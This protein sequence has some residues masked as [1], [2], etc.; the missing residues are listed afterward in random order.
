[1]PS[2]MAAIASVHD[3]IS[4]DSGGGLFAC[5]PVGL[6]P[7]SVDLTLEACLVEVNGQ[8][9]D[10]ATGAAVMGHPAQALAMAANELGRRGL[11]IEPGWI[12]LTGGMT[13]AVDVPPT[14]RWP[15]TSPASGRSSCPSATDHRS[16]RLTPTTLNP[17]TGRPLLG[18]P[19]IPDTQRLCS[20]TPGGTSSVPVS[21]DSRS[22]GEVLWIVAAV[23]SGIRPVEAASLAYKT[24][25]TS[26]EPTGT[27]ATYRRTAALA[28]SGST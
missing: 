1:M 19:P 28:R 4:I 14:A 17:W 15:C 13:Q 22:S 12:V 27:R 21:Q 20:A 5:G 7:A 9:V 6:P 3:A 2:A 18:I 16:C 24:E 8:V 26:H 23:Y 10:S 11:A 25:I